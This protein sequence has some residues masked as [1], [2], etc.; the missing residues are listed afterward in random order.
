ML[1]TFKGMKNYSFFVFFSK[2][3]WFSCFEFFQKAKFKSI[4]CYLKNSN[5]RK[6]YFFAIIKKL[7]LKSRKKN[8]ERKKKWWENQKKKLR[9]HHR[10]FNA[11]DIAV[12]Q[13]TQANL[14][15]SVS[16]FWFDEIF[17]FFSHFRFFSTHF[18]FFSNY[19]YYLL[20]AG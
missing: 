10:F 1:M 16:L 13:L 5:L 6:Y 11:S 4:I 17:F 20:P 15:I 7:P 2:I 18:R 8:M 3:W 12:F 14:T 9:S 19:K